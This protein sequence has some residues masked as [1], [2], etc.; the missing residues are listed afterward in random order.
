MTVL[1]CVASRRSVNV[2]IPSLALVSIDELATR[3]GPAGKGVLLGG[4]G[5]LDRT[6][7][8]IQSEPGSIEHGIS[9]WEGLRQASTLCT[10]WS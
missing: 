1:A 6:P 3:R 2:S 7:L 8:A 9:K 5:A 4:I 10:R